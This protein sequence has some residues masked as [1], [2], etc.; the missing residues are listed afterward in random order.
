MDWAGW[1]VFGIAA[2]VTLTA[3]MVGAQLAGGPIA[4]RRIYLDPSAKSLS[5]QLW[6]DGERGVVPADNA[7][8]DGIAEVAMLVAADRL[9]FHLPS[10]AELPAELAGYTWDPKASEKGEDRP[11]KL[12]DHG[13]DALRYG[14]RGTRSIWR[15]WENRTRSRTR[16]ACECCSPT[17]AWTPC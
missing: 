8:L 5:V 13:P 4:P 14:V 6:R 9:R 12:E 7:V 3:I 10:L 2:T 11:I 15:A 17:T 1:A 16:R